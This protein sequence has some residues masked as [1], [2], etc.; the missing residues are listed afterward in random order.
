[1]YQCRVREY[2]DAQQM[3]FADLVRRVPGVN[4]HTL[5][6]IYYRRT[7]TPRIDIMLEIATGLGVT[8]EAITWTEQA[9]AAATATGA[10]G[11]ASHGSHRNPGR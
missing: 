10:E 6:N 1:M 5:Q 8:V 9:G 2:C 4:P 7:P 3:R 11:D